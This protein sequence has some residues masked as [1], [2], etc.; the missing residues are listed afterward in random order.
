VHLPLSD[1]GPAPD[2]GDLDVVSKPNGEAIRQHGEHPLEVLLLRVRCEA[3]VVKLESLP[4]SGLPQYVGAIVPPAV[5]FQEPDSGRYKGR[6][7]DER[8]K[9]EK[10]SNCTR[11]HWSTALHYT[12]LASHNDE[13]RLV[14][15][16]QG[17]GSI[18]TSEW[19]RHPCQ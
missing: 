9:E 3:E 10:E 4:V 17:W 15:N 19:W 8:D 6:G 16:S 1:L 5:G 13:G 14:I 11:R 2:S 12:T 18:V 7:R